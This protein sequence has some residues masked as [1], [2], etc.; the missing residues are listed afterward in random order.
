MGAYMSA[1]ITDKHGEEGENSNFEYGVSCMQGWRIDM[2]DAHLACLDAEVGEAT[3]V[4]GVFDGHGGRE[5]ANFCSRHLLEVWKGTKGLE[6]GDVAKSL[7][8][9][10]L[11]IDELMKNDSSSAELMELAKKPN[12][13]GTLDS[14]GD[15][16]NVPVSQAQF[17]QL[18]MGIRQGLNKNANGAGGEGGAMADD[19]AVDT[20]V[21]AV[22]GG[23][24]G[25]GADTFMYENRA[26]NGGP[27]AGCTAVVAVIVKDEI[28]VANAGDSRCVFSRGGQAVAMSRDHKP[29]DADEAER[30]HKA[31]GF[32]T[33]GRVNGS[34]NLSRAL[35]DME[36]K[37]R[38]D[39]TPE[40]H[41]VT[42]FPEIFSCKLH[43]DDEFV[44]LACDGIWD[45]MTNQEA[46]TFVRDRIG[47]KSLK[48]ICEDICDFCLAPDTVGVGKG[49]DNMTVMVVKL[50]DPLKSHNAVDHPRKVA[51][52]PVNVTISV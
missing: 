3:G 17:K 22:T 1:P 8:E 51:V 37:Q 15:G 13:D 24:V 38:R 29:Q 9:A 32:V 16:D 33:D 27:N 19:D 7:V 30:I 34:L 46:V 12:R 43:K 47:K 49:C 52:N 42:A 26:S 45:V 10:Y 40:Q 14:A 31:G 11:N 48:Q 21:E 50:K 25:G 2:E 28:V 18:L 6:E 39:L 36:Y 20:M 23:G 44:I 5:V 41:A 35:G 4:Y